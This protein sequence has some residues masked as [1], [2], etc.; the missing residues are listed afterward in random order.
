MLTIENLALQGKQN[1]YNSMAAALGS[2]VL[3]IKKDI[4]KDSMSDFRNSEHRLEHVANIHG[5]EFMNDSKATNVN[6]TWWALESM[7]K[8]VIWIA[9][10]QDKGNDYTMLLEVVKKKVK[11][12]IC[13]GIDN[14]KIIK[15]F[16]ND[17]E[18]IAEVKSM[19]DAIS[20]SYKIGEPGDIV[21]LSPACASYDMFEDYED[22]GRQFKKIVKEF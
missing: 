15:A 12:I 5:I 6:S 3:E 22:R 8:P 21:L 9:G 4:L 18:L 10:G 14:N 20:F 11:A 16:R 2:R 17:I 7:N 19:A 13:L 1:V